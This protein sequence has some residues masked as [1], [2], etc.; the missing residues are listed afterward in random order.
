VVRYLARYTSRI[1]TSNSRITRVDLVR[2]TVT[3]TWKDPR[4]G[5]RNREMTMDGGTFLRCFTR[6]LVPKGFRRIRYF[7]LL[8]GA[9]NRI[10]ELEEAP[11]E[12]SGEKA[13]AQT[14][15]ECPRCGGCEWTYQPHCETHAMIVDEDL[16]TPVI[17]HSGSMTCRFS[18]FLP[19]TPPENRPADPPA[20]AGARPPTPHHRPRITGPA[21]TFPVQQADDANAV[22]LEDELAYTARRRI[23]LTFANKSIP[24]TTNENT[25]A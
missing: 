17:F 8:A 19:A 23:S 25:N 9:R 10:A 22:D 20:G 5:G 2:R 4:H 12:T 21:G 11:Q 14:R 6:H 7:G 16:R 24:K 1:A 3:F 15:P 13:P 18:R